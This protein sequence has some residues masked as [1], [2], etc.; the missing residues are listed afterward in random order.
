MYYWISG[1]F[2]CNLINLVQEVWRACRYGR[3]PSALRF[4]KA[5]KPS[6][7]TTKRLIVG[8]SP[9][10]SRSCSAGRGIYHAKGV[11]AVQTHSFTFFKVLSEKMW[12]VA[13]FVRLLETSI[14]NVRRI[15]PIVERHVEVPGSIALRL[16]CIRERCHFMQPTRWKVQHLPLHERF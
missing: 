12:Q 14:G 3:S 7:E 4:C 15:K 6:S 16:A 2:P 9:R 13:A 10:L 1:S 5:I 8:S 11:C